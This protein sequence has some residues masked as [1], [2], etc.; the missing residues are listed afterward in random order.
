[1]PSLGV[2]DKRIEVECRQMRNQKEKPKKNDP[3]VFFATRNIIFGRN[4]KGYFES[5]HFL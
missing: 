2:N 5:D 3:K 1:M 4:I